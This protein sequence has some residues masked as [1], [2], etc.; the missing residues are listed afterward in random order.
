LIGA[1][2]YANRDVNNSSGK[3]E[4]IRHIS[5]CTGVDLK[6]STPK[7]H[8]KFNLFRWDGRKTSE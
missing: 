6:L 1:T 8:K 5:S 7:Y 4:L 3:T 2:G